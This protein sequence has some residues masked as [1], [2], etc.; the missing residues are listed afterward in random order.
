[1]TRDNNLESFPM[2]LLTPEITAWV[3]RTAPP[4]RVEISRRDIVKYAIATEQVRACYLCGDEAPPMFVFGLF[5]PLV[6]MAE[7][8]PDGIAP[9]SFTPQL[10]LKRTMAGGMKLNIH[11]PIHPGDTLIGTQKFVD[12]FEKNGRQGPLIFVV[13]ELAI[14][15]ESG[16]PVMEEIQTRIAR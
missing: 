6:E 14:T 11:R 1:M 7:L 8:G 15:T 2:G 5:K 10:P 13:N 4:V 3:G 16:E 12:I 9:T